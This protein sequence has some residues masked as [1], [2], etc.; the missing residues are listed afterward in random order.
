MNIRERWVN[1]LYRAATGT[2]TTRTLLTPIGIAIFALFTALF[3]F[4]AVL[5]DGGRFQSLSVGWCRFQ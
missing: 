4:L 3:V 2:K 1:L 5:L